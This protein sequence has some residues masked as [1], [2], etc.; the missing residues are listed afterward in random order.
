LAIS[1]DAK[2]EALTDHYKDT[3][4]YV[5]EYVAIR[6]RLFLLVLVLLGLQFFQI[7][8]PDTSSTAI[9]DFF[10][11]HLG[12]QISADKHSLNAI[13]W[14]ALLSV[15]VRYFQ[16]NVYINRQYKYLHV[17]EDKFTRLFGEKTIIREGKHYLSAYPL[18][19]DWT[20][21][22]YTW[23]FPVLLLLTGGFKIYSDWPGNNDAGMA[24]VVSC[25]FYLMIVISTV[26]HMNFL[27]FGKKKS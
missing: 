2:L 19:S 1:D 26:L 15:V 12:F 18:F 7:S 25:I 16:A 17:L 13:L 14:F 24:Y 21:C 5:R 8:S 22:L 9:V 3:F 11:N 27:H 6:D 10:K 20:N 4:H 23:V